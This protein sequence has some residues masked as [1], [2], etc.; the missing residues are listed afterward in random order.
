MGQYW[1]LKRV[2]PYRYPIFLER[3]LCNDKVFPLTLLK[4]TA[5][6]GWYTLHI[7]YFIH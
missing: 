7:Q 1:C 3:A 5:Q 4:E 6:P 2:A